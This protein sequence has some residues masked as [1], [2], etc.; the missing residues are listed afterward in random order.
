MTV[1]QQRDQAGHEEAVGERGGGRDSHR[2]GGAGVVAGHRALEVQRGRLHSF[3]LSHDRL[4]C[5]GWHEAV[6]RTGEQLAAEL[7]LELREAPANR[8]VPHS[9]DVGRTGQTPCP[10]H[11]QEEPHVVPLPA[12]RKGV[13]YW[14]SYVNRKTISIPHRRSYSLSV[15]FSMGKHSKSR[16]K[17]FTYDKRTESHY[18]MLQSNTTKEVNY[19]TH[20]QHY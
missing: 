12:A 13:H 19:G 11:G 17:N 14:T 10:Y 2:T 16:M 8:D 4:A 5:G 20:I 18:G 1:T 15:T 3:A 9:E 6:G 7:V